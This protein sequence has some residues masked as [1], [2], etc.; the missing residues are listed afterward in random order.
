M[1]V[2]FAALLAGACL[3][4]SGASASPVVLRDALQREVTFASP[5]QRIVTLLPSLTETV[6][7]LGA[8]DRLVATD[9][10]S[11]WPPAVRALPKAGGIDDAQIEL[12]VSL[13]P[14]LILISRS[15]RISGRLDAL[16]LRCFALVTDSYADIARNVTRIGAMLALE[17]RAAR[18]NASIRDSVLEIGAQALAQRHGPGPTVYFEADGPPYA[19]GPAS[20]IGELLERLGARNIVSADQGPFPALNPE[21]VVR[22]NPDVIFVSP[23]E[24]THLAERPGWGEIRA[25]REQRVCSFVP[26]IRDSIIRPGP[27]VAEGMRA[28]GACLTRVSP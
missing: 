24:A 12:L 20:F 7:A 17:E 22:H 8:C 26:A 18:L 13:K 11:D 19:A 25:V 14:D 15:Q 21:Y 4:G 28:L 10:Y 5:P 16:G 6:C 9:R 1:S 27:R 2:K 23:A 3:I